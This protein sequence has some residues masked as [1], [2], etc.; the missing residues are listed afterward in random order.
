MFGSAESNGICNPGIAE[1][2]RFRKIPNRLLCSAVIFIRNSKRKPDTRQSI[3]CMPDQ[4][5]T[6]ILILGTGGA[7]LMAALHAFWRDPSLKW[8]LVSKVMLGR[9]SC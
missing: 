1:T 3:R 9:S 4:L 6:D 2:R 7:G 8:H 5:T